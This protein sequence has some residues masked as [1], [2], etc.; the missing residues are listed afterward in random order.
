[1][2][3]KENFSA[4]QLQKELKIVKQPQAAAL[5]SRQHSREA[6]PFL[7]LKK[8]LKSLSLWLFSPTGSRQPSLACTLHHLDVPV[9]FSFWLLFFGKLAN[10]TAVKKEGKANGNGGSVLQQCGFWYCARSG[11]G[12]N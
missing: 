6:A 11:D 8:N 10:G 2:E 3:K 1:M 9:F 12:K 5:L 7:D 4:Q